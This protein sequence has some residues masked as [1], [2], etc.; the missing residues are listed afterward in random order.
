MHRVKNETSMTTIDNS[1]LAQEKQNKNLQGTLN[2]RNTC[3]RNSLCIMYGLWEAEFYLF[4]RPF[5]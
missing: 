5:F 1:Y 3:L 4:N 2:L